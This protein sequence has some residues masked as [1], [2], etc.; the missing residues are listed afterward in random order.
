MLI[1]VF[2]ETINRETF[3]KILD[4]YNNNKSED[5][6]S[7][8]R[9]DRFEGGFQ[10]KIKNMENKYTDENNKIRQL[11]WA[12]GALVS[13]LHIGFTEKQYLL[14]YESL[15]YA[16]GGNVLLENSRL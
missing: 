10:I 1:R 15:V 13:G 16:L 9:L 4:Y 12:N 6:E 14:L 11:R 5:E 2:A 7:L 8:E 3:Q